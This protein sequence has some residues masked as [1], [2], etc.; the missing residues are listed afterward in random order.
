[1]ITTR[2][3]ALRDTAKWL[4]FVVL[5]GLFIYGLAGWAL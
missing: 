4:A 1:M 3:Q 2:Q 5:L